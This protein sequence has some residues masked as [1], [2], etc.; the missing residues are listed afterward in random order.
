MSF[1]RVEQKL[2]NKKANRRCDYVKNCQYRP[3]HVAVHTPPMNLRRW[4]LS[5]TVPAKFAPAKQ[6]F[7]KARRAALARPVEALPGRAEALLA[8]EPELEL[9]EGL[10]LPC[11]Q[12]KSQ[13]GT[14]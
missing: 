1:L 9:E 8:L 3:R 10:G 2:D 12:K 14:G 13:G 6:V 5:S 7:I 11:T 4:R